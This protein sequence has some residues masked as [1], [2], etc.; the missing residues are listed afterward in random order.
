MA[1]LRAPLPRAYRA[2]PI[3]DLHRLPW[4]YRRL[5][6]FCVKKWLET[7][8]DEAQKA[9]AL[10]VAHRE[11]LRLAHSYGDGEA[12]EE[13]FSRRGGEGAWVLADSR[14]PDTLLAEARRVEY[15][16]EDSNIPGEITAMTLKDVE[17]VAWDINSKEQEA[18]HFMFKWV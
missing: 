6:R 16:E 7:H 14:N 8:N 17:K 11:Y 4:D 5:H 12:S 9:E 3:R 1:A 13:S 10:I 2:A 15:K 18:D